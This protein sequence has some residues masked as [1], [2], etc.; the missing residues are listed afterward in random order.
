MKINKLLKP[1]HVRISLETAKKR[2]ENWRKFISKVFIGANP[3]TMPKAVYISKKDIEALSVYTLN[4]KVYGVR[5]YF[6]LDSDYV[7]HPEQNNIRLIMVPVGEAEGM[8]N[9]KDMFKWSA[10][11]LAETTGEFAAEEG[12]S[13][14]YDFTAPCPDCC[15][16]TS[17]LYGS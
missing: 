13:S 1:T 16:T 2:T 15:D 3:A 12:D 5:A 6:T 4:P 17:P 10:D 9:G 7:L 11:F 8:E 14:I